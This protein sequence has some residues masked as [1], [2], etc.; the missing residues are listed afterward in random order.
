MRICGIKRIKRLFDYG[1]VCVCGQRGRGKDLLMSNVAVRSR[2]YVSNIDY[3]NGY[4]PLDISKLEV[5]NTYKELVSGKT[6]TYIYPYP[7]KVDIYISDIGVYFP[8]QYCDKL[9]REYPT[10]PVFLALSRQ[11]GNDV[12]VHWNC[13]YLGRCW[14]KF[15]EQSDT[16]IYCLGVVKP[17]LRIGLA[18]QRLRVYELYESAVKRVPPFSVPKP[19]LSAKKE[20][21]QAYEIEKARYDQ[22]YGKVRDYLVIYRHK[23]NYDDRHFKTL[24]ER[25]EETIEQKRAEVSFDTTCSCGADSILL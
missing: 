23:S 25:C 18:V 14:D 15:R 9:N 22:Q 6:N 1:S 10:I 21:K 19:K 16:Y 17:F 13:Q 5:N 4:I 3:G 12:S 7:E 2:H 11:L 20:I 8:S 24:L